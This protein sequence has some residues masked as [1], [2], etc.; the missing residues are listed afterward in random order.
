MNTYHTMELKQGGIAN[1]LLAIDER[2]KSKN[3]KCGGLCFSRNME[4]IV[5]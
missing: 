4:E 1:I 2:V 3:I 5:I